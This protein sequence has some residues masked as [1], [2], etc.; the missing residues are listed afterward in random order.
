MPVRNEADILPWTIQH[1]VD[2]G[3]EVYVIDNWSTDGSWEMLSWLPISGRERFPSSGPEDRYNCLSM[4]HRV[5]E[6]AAASK[7]DW[8]IFHDADEI[9][10]SP[11][12]GETIVRGLQRVEAEGYNAINHN[13]YLFR[14][15][16]DDY[17]G[18]PER[19]FSY[20][21]R[22]HVDCGLNHVKAWKNTGR[23]TGLG[24]RAAGGGHAF[25]FA[26]MTV[27]P[28]KWVL[29]HY[30][31]RGQRHGARKMAERLSRWN[32]EE[33]SWGWH[34]QYK[35]LSPGSNFLHDPNT[36]QCWEDAVAPV[37]IV[38]MS[39]FKDIFLRLHECINQYAPTFPC[40]MVSDGDW[41][42]PSPWTV[43]RGKR[44]FVFARNWNV[45]IEATDS[46]SD[47]LFTNDD[48]IFSQPGTVDE[49]R[50][51][52]YSKTSIG[53]VSPQM[54]GNAANPM[55]MSGCRL[56]EVTVTQHELAFVCVYIKR[57]V[58]SAVGKMDERFTGYGSDDFD[59]CRR[60]QQAG[61]TLAV[62]PK[63]TVIHGH[64]NSNGSTSY[65][66]IMS[67]SDWRESMADMNRV[68]EQ[69]W[70]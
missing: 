22:T 51:A 17:I 64:D 44:P 52:A 38:T 67:D 29:K 63:V 14:A 37:T 68:L 11:R 26:G 60:A 3:V 31:I 2:Q 39:R 16:D 54:A 47:V 46:D 30:P 61:F 27:H 57:A 23:L 40:L 69:K 20:Y 32:L 7:A 70:A 19:H 42:S 15:I 10:R 5:D 56:R 55:Q 21:T 53:I 36:L 34:V 9:R 41:V 18:D 48:V 24:T 58:L 43:V 28:Q 4:L 33:R 25:G 65:R 62:T 35:G 45:G 66:R 59:F 12:P 6:V 50:R 8:C 49:L 1:L 13:L